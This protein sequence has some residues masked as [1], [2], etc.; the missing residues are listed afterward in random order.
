MNEEADSIY[1]SLVEHVRNTT[2]STSTV[3]DQ[4]GDVSELEGERVS[5]NNIYHVISMTVDC[6]LITHTHPRVYFL[7]CLTDCP[8]DQTIQRPET[9]DYLVK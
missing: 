4:L 9:G 5:R 1:F 7:F 6:G 3:Q 8:S 2:S